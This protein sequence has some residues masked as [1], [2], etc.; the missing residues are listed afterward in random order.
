MI[1]GQPHS[2]ISS[3]SGSARAY[4]NQE[5]ASE[6]DQSSS[7][8]V[9]KSQC[10]TQ[11]SN[12]PAAERKHHQGQGHQAPRTGSCSSPKAQLSKHVGDEQLPPHK[13]DPKSS[14]AVMKAFHSKDSQHIHIR[15]DWISGFLNHQQDFPHTN[16]CLP[17]CHVFSTFQPESHC[18]LH[19][20][21]HVRKTIQQEANC[22]MP[23]REK[24]SVPGH[25][26]FCLNMRQD[27]PK[28]TPTTKK[29]QN[30]SLNVAPFWDASPPFRDLPNSSFYT[31]FLQI[32]RH[33]LLQLFKG[34]IFFEAT[35]LFFG[36]KK[37]HDLRIWK[38]EYAKK[39][40]SHHPKSVSRKQ[41]NTSYQ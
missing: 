14:G 3:S 27:P 40:T 35:Q 32:Q 22:Q 41:Q 4:Q 33:F 20:T 13:L 11:E 24:A 28:K 18:H 16:R 34:S 21:W 7:A 37:N 26:F 17:V 31:C 12:P 23:Q 25:L 6:V 2:Q 8:A 9:G 1:F 30:R 38:Y 39:N 10:T 29:T 19:R 15:L 5:A 36:F